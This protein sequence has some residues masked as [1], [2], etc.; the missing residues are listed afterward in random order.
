MSRDVVVTLVVAVPV[1]AL[2]LAVFYVLGDR[3]SERRAA[4]RF[5][6]EVETY[7]RHRG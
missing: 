5:A 1:P 2:L 3:I 7:M 4:R 6:I